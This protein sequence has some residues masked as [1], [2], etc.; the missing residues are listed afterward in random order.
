VD[1]LQYQGKN[2]KKKAN[3]NEQEAEIFLAD[4]PLPDDVKEDCPELAEKV[5][6]KVNALA[7]QIRTGKATREEANEEIL[8]LLEQDIMDSLLGALSK[9]DDDIGRLAD[10]IAS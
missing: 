4:H 5:E 1:A 7:E 10:F 3:I 8:D 9:T 6:A 2:M